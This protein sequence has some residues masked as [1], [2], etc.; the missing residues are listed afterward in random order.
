MLCIVPVVNAKGGNTKIKYI[1][2]SIRSSS[3]SLNSTTEQS[4]SGIGI[5]IYKDFDQN[6]GWVV[7]QL[8][9][10][11]EKRL[12]V[13]LAKAQNKQLEFPTTSRGKKVKDLE[14]QLEIEVEKRNLRPLIR[15]EIKD[16]KESVGLIFEMKLLGG[17]L[18]NSATTDVINVL[19]S[20]FGIGVRIDW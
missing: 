19:K 2:E 9:S 17:T 20:S 6:S 1:N 3:S 11:K 18:T 8:K 10:N 13:K 7:N 16:E 12:E 14:K 15:N 4:L 5:E